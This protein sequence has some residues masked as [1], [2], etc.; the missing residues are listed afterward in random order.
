MYLEQTLPINAAHIRRS[1]KE[2]CFFARR[3][4]VLLAQ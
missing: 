1:P 2:S 4:V 3:R